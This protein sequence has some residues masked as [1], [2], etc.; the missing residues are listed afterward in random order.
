[1]SAQVFVRR[2]GAS[3][4]EVGN[5][6]VWRLNGLGFSGRGSRTIRG[7]KPRG[8]LPAGGT[9]R[10]PDGQAEAK[11]IRMRA[12][13]STARAPTLS[14]LFLRVAN[15]AQASGIRRG[16]ASRRASISQ[17]GR[18]VQDEAEL[19]GDR[20]LAGGPVGGELALVQL[21]QVLRHEGPAWQA[22]PRPWP[23]AQ[24]PTAARLRF[25]RS[26]EPNMVAGIEGM[27]RHGDGDES[28]SDRRGPR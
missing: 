14:R 21:D 26:C 6:W 13:L 19:V 25:D 22:S 2:L 16:T 9:G 1:M 5:V 28:R 18:G 24:P 17:V 7:P 8:A 11:W 3:G 10:R 4:F 12:A 23:P 15:S 20:A 27:F